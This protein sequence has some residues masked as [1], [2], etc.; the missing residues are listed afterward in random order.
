MYVK[1]FSPTEHIGLSIWGYITGSTGRDVFFEKQMKYLWKSRLANSILD[2]AYV[3]PVYHFPMRQ[4]ILVSPCLQQKLIKAMHCYKTTRVFPF[5][6]VYSIN[7]VPLIVPEISKRKCI[8]TSSGLQRY[9][10]VPNNLRS[11]GF[12][13]RNRGYFN[14]R[15]KKQGVISP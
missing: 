12:H 14:L 1:H 8:A 10:N 11:P 15:K 7:G 13:R 9:P 5:L 6:H 2:F 4:P 3:S